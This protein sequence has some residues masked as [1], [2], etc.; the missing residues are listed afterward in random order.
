MTE[1]I[2]MR[3]KFAEKPSF[4]DAFKSRGCLIPADGFYKWQGQTGKKQTGAA[5]HIDPSRTEA[6]GKA[7]QTTFDWPEHRQPAQTE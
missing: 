5:G 4:R 1:P 3:D 7:Q 6:A 2:I